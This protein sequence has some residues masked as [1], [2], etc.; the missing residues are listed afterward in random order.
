MS[1]LPIT[2]DKRFAT[3]VWRDGKGF[4]ALGLKFQQNVFAMLVKGKL[5]VKLPRASGG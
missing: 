5:V 1:H 4:S 2:P 3:L